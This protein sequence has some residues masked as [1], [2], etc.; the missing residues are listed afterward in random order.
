MQQVFANGADELSRESVSS[1]QVHHFQPNFTAQS[2]SSVVAPSII[3]ST[4]NGNININLISSSQGSNNQSKEVLN[5]DHTVNCGTL[6]PQNDETAECQ[7]KLKA[8][9]KMKFSHWHEEMLKDAN[10]TSLNKIYTE[11]YIT[12][13]GCGEVSKEHEVRQIEMTSKIHLKQEKPIHCND[14]FAPQPG[15][16]YRIRTVLTRGIAGIGKTVSVNKFALDWAEEKANTDLEFVFPLSFRELNLMR[17][18]T[19]SLEELLC[20]FFPEI[21]GKEIFTNGGKKM[22]FILDGLDESRL[23]LNFQETEIMSDVTQQTMIVV[24]LTNLIRGNLLP[25]AL[26][27]ITSRPVASSQIPAEHIFLVTEVR[28]FSNPQKE[29]YFMKNIADESL[30]KRVIAHVKSC[31]TLHIMCHIPVFCWMAASVLKKKLALKDS[32]DTPKTL[33]QMYIQF[34]CLNVENMKNR[35]PERRESNAKCVRDNLLALGKLAF[36]ELGKGH[37]NFYERDLILNG[38]DV[39]QASMFSGVYTQIFNQEMTLCEEKMFCFVHLTIHEFFAALYV[40]LTFNNENINVLVK[41][42]SASRRFLSRESSELILYKAAVEKAMGSE[43]GQFDIFLR[44]LL[45]LSL[46]SNQKLLKNLMTGNRT[47]QRTRDEIIKYIKEKIRASHSPDRC[48]NLFHCLNE[49]NDHSLVEEIQSFISSGSLSKASL[50]MGQ[51]ATL[52]FVLLTSEEELTVFELSKYTRSE[53]GLLRL[54]PVVKTTR[55]AKLNACNLTVACCEMLSNGISSSHLRELDL[56][57]NNLTDTGLIKLSGGLKNKTLRTIRLKSC[58]LTE[59]SSDSL[60]S[61]IS[62]ASGKLRV[63]DLTDNDLQDVGVRRLSSGLVS[64]YCKLEI[65]ILSGCRVTEEGSIFLAS[66]LNTASLRELDLS[67]NHPGNSGI[68]LLSALLE[69]PHCSLEKLSVDHCDNSRIQP[70]P[71]KYTTKLTLDPNTAHR[72]ISLS[73]GDMKATRWTKQSYPDHPERF[74]YWRQVLCEQ[75]LI[76]RYYWEVEWSGIVCIGVAYRGM[77][78][79]GKGHDCWLGRN[80]SSWV[81]SCARDSYRILHDSVSAAVNATPSSNTVGVYLDCPAGILSFYGV[82][83]GTLTLLYTIHTTFTEPVYPGFHFDWVDSTVQLCKC[84]VQEFISPTQ[85]VVHQPNLTA[86]SSSNLVA[87]PI[88]GS[89]IGNI[90]IRII[91][92]SQGSNDQSKHISNQ[93][94]TG[95]CGTLQPQN[96]ET[97]ECQQK[98]KAA[99]K[100]KFSHWHEET[101][102]DVNK[103]SLNKIYTE[104]YITEGGCGEVSKEHEVRQIEMAF[105]IHLKQEKPI[106]CNDLFTPQPGRDYRIRTVLTRG[107]A[108]IGKTV[109][110]NKFALDWAEE[111][112]NTDLE[113]VFPL[114][115]R[116][117]NLMREKTLSLEEHLCVFFPEIKGKE[118]F[119]NGGKKMLFILDGLDESRLSL[120]FQE[121]EIMSDVTQK[122]KIAV[123]LTNLIRENLLPLALVWITSR[124]IA[125][126]QIPFKHIDLIT[127][128]R[129]FNN[130]QKEE[131]FMKNIADESLAKR[132]IAHV[133]SCRTLHIMCHI[134]V[135]CWMAASVLKKKLALKD[136]KDTPKTLTQMYI[137]FLSLCVEKMK[138]RLPESRDSNA[139][140]VRDNLLVLGKLAFK[141]LKNCHLIFYERDLTS[142]GINVTQDFTFSGVYTEVFN[143]EMTLCEEKMFCFVHLTIHEF[144]AALYVFLTFNN[145][146]SNVLVKKWHPYFLFRKSSDL[147]L[148]KAAVEKAMGSENGHFDIFLRFLLGMSLESNQTLLK[149]LMTSNRTHQRTRDKIIKNI[150][151]K[152][153]SS[154]SVDRCLNLFHC[155]NELNDDSLVEEIQSFLS[156]GSLSKTSLSPGQWATL[157]FVLLTSEEELTVF[158]LSKYTRSEEGLLRLLPVVKTTRIAKLNA[159]N[160]T[161]DCCEMLSNGISSSHLRE[162]DLS[163]NNLTDTG[164]IKLSGG[165]KNKTL[166]TIRLKSCSLTEHSSDSLASIISI[167]SGKLRVLDLTDNDLQDVG[168]R[169][170]SSGLVSPYCKLEILIL[171]GCRVTEEG[172]IFLASALNTA[173]L[174]EL[175]LSYNHPGNSGIMLLSALLEDPHCSL[176]KLSVDHCDN[177]R[178]QPS[179]KKYTTK[180]TLDPN[181]AHRDISLSEGDMKATRWTKQSYP[182][183]PER[184]NYWRQ[185]LCEQGLI[186]RYYWEVE[187]SGIVCIGVAYRGMCRKGKGHDCWLGRNDSSWVLSCARDSYRI[188]HDSVSAAVNATPSSN[189][190][191]VYLDCPAGILSFYGVSS[192]TLTLLYTIHTTFTEPVYPGFHFDWVDSTVQLC[193]CMFS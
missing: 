102:K 150:K 190:V 174:R 186:G 35:L 50:S 37:F 187:W 119:T 173:S 163:N 157:V 92:S 4:I 98:L 124:P 29:E 77:C 81:L 115:F 53:E 9:L 2:S 123:I 74:D 117:L 151:K 97:T 14:L 145:N 166:R 126:S 179:P 16:D 33:T 13:E 168:V 172:S 128:V 89:T 139:K 158:E 64:P 181:T 177:S 44:F 7:Q 21:K 154:K 159:C 19:F 1:L 101:L 58:S 193:K 38:I 12:E 15:R 85:A 164:L 161:M 105:E 137:Q 82:S 54:L 108:G 178:I 39:T 55:I 165:L 162:L 27:W 36:K 72:D 87:L 160:L 8:A 111:K 110:V 78:R 127:E 76:G 133:K 170:L 107:I 149:S 10:K 191:G 86:Q 43:N 184:F 61:I 130:L 136:S 45:G 192:G 135:F 152:I 106:H 122:T 125:S 175:D 99:L 59:H 25:L 60:A 65:L 134:P 121:T 31:R 42:S 153:R 171:S 91:S 140:C 24:I 66:A 109:S 167:A 90:N 34:L 48:L 68:M 28:G 84:I 20:V 103:T 104:L 69:D 176:E 185:V 156:S 138:N 30:A 63:L 3:G 120:S 94:N 40:F 182:D 95:N 155:L 23:S 188:L 80:D 88:N 47:H 116:E 26:V 129:G 22:L 57:N 73:E 62:I 180:L 147:I 52:V 32:K 189:T 143:Q 141:E 131:Y 144:F 51:W 18:K 146:N 183:H 79:K 17:E 96:D 70:S 112:A 71:K 100:M 148:Y 11:L 56:S 169:R 118:I 142:N 46:E 75:G 113:F 93:D 6:Q 49:L 41:K 114:S 132:V 67:Y 5:Q 83:S